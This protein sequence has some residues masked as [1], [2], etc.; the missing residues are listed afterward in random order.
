MESFKKLKIGTQLALSFGT[1]TALM[2]IL[3]TFAVVRMSSITGA[4]QL[5]QQVAAQKL[6]PLYVAREALAQTGL[7]ARNAYIFT[8][9]AQA[10]KELALL[11]EQKAVYLA[12]LE[13]MTPAYAGDANF[14]KVRSGLLKMADALKRP[15]QLREAG[16][17]EAFG[18]FLTEE[19]SPL[20]RQI[21]TDI[22]TVMAA[23]QAETAA[24]SAGVNA[25]ASDARL[26]IVLQAVLS[27]VV[28]V[29]IAWANTRLLL[30]Q[31]GGEP[32]YAT[33]IANK[34]A[35]GDLAI[36]VEVKS[37]DKTS[38]LHA[39]KAMRDS[40][41]SI[42]GQV[43]QGT[44][45]IATA[46]SEI[47]SG[48]RDLSLRTEHQAESL[49]KVAT[50]M[51]ELTSTVKQNAGN[52]QQA[53]VLAVSAS[54]VSEQGG[55]VMEQVTVTMASINESSKKIVDIISVI[56]GIAFQTNI[57]ALNAAVE[58]ARAGEQGR[59]FAVVATE[60]RNLAQRSAAA[61][62]EIKS[63]IDDSVEKVGTGSELVHKAGETMHE[64]VASVK[65]VTE[66]MGEISGA[67]MEQTAGIEQVNDAIGEMDSMTQQNTALVEQATAA[68]QELQDQASSLAHVVDVFKLEAGKGPRSASVVG[69]RGHA[70]R[71]PAAASARRNDEV[72]RIANG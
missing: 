28:S 10:A 55:Q 31:L 26:W 25:H 9:N 38:L 66:I 67:S 50:A 62:K 59:G 23:A 60:V 65:R 8:D 52:A 58:A 20:R 19:C 68:A 15:R 40:L 54:E 57:L 32:A 14:D 39:I 17:N 51:E 18:R 41:S 5:Q 1:L 6:E 16:D 47:A 64:V 3:A 21:V 34:I 43:R 7:A 12:A 63:L 4:F 72:R 45:M 27:F 48:N 53:N 44:D 49:E 24:A 30:K 35:E 70:R 2:L 46:S 13:K 69:M 33:E 71:Q 61:A 37:D 56:D 42:V 22:A 29:L 11:D 36:D